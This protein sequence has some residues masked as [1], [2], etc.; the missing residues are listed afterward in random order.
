MTN[1]LEEQKKPKVGDEKWK[2]SIES[3]I[4]REAQP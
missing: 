2:K 4:K 1:I 3:I